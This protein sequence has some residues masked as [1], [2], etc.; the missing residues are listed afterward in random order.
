MILP[1]CECFDDLPS[2]KDRFAAIYGAVW[3]NAGSPA[4]L[5]SYSCIGQYSIEEILKYWYCA[6]LL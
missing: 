5:P 4:S 1:T 2:L 3:V 6:L